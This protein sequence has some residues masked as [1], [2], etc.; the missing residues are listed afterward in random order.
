MDSLLTQQGNAPEE[1]CHTDHKPQLL[2]P[3]RLESQPSP[4]KVQSSPELHQS[5]PQTIP[6]TPLL[7]RPSPLEKEG[8]SSDKK[9]V[10]Q[11]P[12]TWVPEFSVP[13]LGCCDELHDFSSLPQEVDKELLV[14][15][16]DDF[17]TVDGQFIVYH[18]KIATRGSG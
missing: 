18:Q 8:G 14:F 1:G 11:Y 3:S 4:H 9:S 12:R 5:T 17:F 7:Q 16:D 2:Q 13:E 15:D 6:S 10:Y